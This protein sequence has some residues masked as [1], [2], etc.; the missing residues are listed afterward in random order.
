MQ[1]H[2]RLQHCTAICALYFLTAT[3]QFSCLSGERTYHELQG[4][5]SPDNTKSSASV[6]DKSKKKKNEQQMGAP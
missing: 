2:L 4:M 3:S 1:I 6:A 5:C